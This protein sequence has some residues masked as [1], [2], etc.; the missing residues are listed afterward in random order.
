VSKDPNQKSVRQ[1]T[2][3]THL[4]QCIG[5]VVASK[6]CPDTTLLKFKLRR[7]QPADECSPL[8]SESYT[9]DKG[10]DK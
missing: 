9:D 3:S 1:S 8:D 10:K 5:V 7:R 2:N 6:Q 4:I